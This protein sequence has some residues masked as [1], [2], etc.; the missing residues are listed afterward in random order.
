MEVF[1]VIYKDMLVY[2]VA[3]LQGDI[4]EGVVHGEVQMKSLV[5]IKLV[6]LII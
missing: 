2:L 4:G 3:L 6:K 1:L 5:L